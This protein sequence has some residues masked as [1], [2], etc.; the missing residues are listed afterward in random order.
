MN[1]ILAVM[2]IK[3]ILV[4]TPCQLKFCNVTWFEYQLKYDTYLKDA[5]WDFSQRL[6]IWAQQPIK[7]HPSL[8]TSWGNML[9]GWN[10]VWFCLSHFASHLQSQDCVRT[11][12]IFERTRRMVSWRTIRRYSLNLTKVYW[13][14]TADYTFTSACYISAASAE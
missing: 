1:N 2:Q 6:L 14:T 11:P 5:D 7:L 12:S 10:S 13:I 3:S 4:W 9:I 8:P